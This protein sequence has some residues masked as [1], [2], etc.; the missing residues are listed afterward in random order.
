MNYTIDIFTLTGYSLF[1]VSLFL[2]GFFVIRTRGSNDGYMFLYVAIFLL[3][4]ELL[5][6]TLVH[7][8]FLLE[9]P[10]LYLPGRYYNILIYPVF[11]LFVWSIIRPMFKLK[12]WH[13]L[14][15]L[16]LVISSLIE[17]VTA[18]MIPEEEKI[19]MM[20]AF[21]ADSRP[22]P[23]NYWM[24]LESFLLSTGIPL[25][26]ICRI[27]YDFYGFA[28]QRTNPQ[29]QRLVILVGI[30]IIIYFLFY[31]FSNFIYRIFYTLTGYSMI[32][33]PVDITFLS[34]VLLLLLILTLL[35]NTGSQFFPPSKYTGSGLSDRQYK[36]LLN[37][38]RQL[39]IEEA[40]YKKDIQLKELANRIETNPKY[41][42]QAINHEL[43]R[44]YTDFI[45]AYRVS[46]AKRLMKEQKHEHLTLEAI[47]K[48][49]GFNSKSAF[50]RAFKKEAQITPNQ[51][52]KDQI[53]RNS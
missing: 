46:E 14:A 5:Y 16:I 39:I 52:L 44:N 19:S 27:G 51:F 9:F 36:T 30:I 28:K 18:L 35:V 50:F 29:N 41:L 10:W 4:F 33:W 37:G 25:L 17:W 13:R 12:M 32:E 21:F 53:S 42:S 47:G 24:N 26:F 31:Q 40:L 15:L 3:A 48:M 2:M 1:S 45:N 22:G 8:R 34:I 20:K 6:K 7:S 11:L 23:Y 43:G 49:A 38:A